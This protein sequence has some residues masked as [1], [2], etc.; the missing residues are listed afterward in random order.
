ML[1]YQPRFRDPE[2][3]ALPRNIADT[4]SGERGLSPVY[5]NADLTLDIETPS[6]EVL[7]IDARLDHEAL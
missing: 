4:A 7:A 1:L 5:A 3:A 2:H 6:G